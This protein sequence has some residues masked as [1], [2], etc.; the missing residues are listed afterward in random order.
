MPDEYDD[1]GDVQ[2]GLSDQYRKASPWP[3]LVAFGFVIS[4]VGVVLGLFPI[5]VGGLLLFGGTVSGILSESGYAA[6]T[7]RSLVAFGV[8]LLAFGALTVGLNISVG[9]LSLEALLD[10]ARPFVYRG[11]AITAAGLIL[12]AVG[13]TLHLVE[14]SPP[15]P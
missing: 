6:Q 9:A 11:S 5:T 12:V 15:S 10:T 14:P 7:W 1:A 4:E 2:P 13:V 8:V 3:M